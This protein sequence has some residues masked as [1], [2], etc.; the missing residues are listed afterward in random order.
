M[1]FCIWLLMACALPAQ[2]DNAFSGRQAAFTMREAQFNNRLGAL[3]TAADKDGS[4]T[5]SREEA[6]SVPFVSQ[7]FKAMDSNEDGEISREE[8]EGFIQRQKS[9]REAAFR[10]RQEGMAGRG[11]VASPVEEAAP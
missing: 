6:A 7:N 3:F 5:L 10:Q 4:G 9:A 11:S 1:R 8:M 2:A